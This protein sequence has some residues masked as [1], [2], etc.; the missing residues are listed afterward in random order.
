MPAAAAG[1]EEAIRQPGAGL[2]IGKARKEGKCAVDWLEIV[3]IVDSPDFPANVTDWGVCDEIGWSIAHEAARQ[4]KLPDGFDQW[5]LSTE[6]GWSVA[7]EAACY[8]ELPE[9]FNQ[10]ELADS[11]GWTV[12]HEAARLGCL[13]ADFDQWDMTDNAGRTVAQI[14]ELYIEDQNNGKKL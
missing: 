9:E 6:G 10:W 4:G 14:L 5:E 12:A 2:R 1:G 8:G 7:H 13:P 11:K 3:G